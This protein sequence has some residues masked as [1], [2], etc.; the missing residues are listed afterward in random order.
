MA[1]NTILDEVKKHSAWNIFMGLLMAALGILLMA[2]PFATGA[3]TTV[4]IGWTLVLA[5]AADDLFFRIAGPVAAWPTGMALCLASEAEAHAALIDERNLQM[6]L[7]ALF[8]YAAGLRLSAL[9]APTSQN[10]PAIL[11]LGG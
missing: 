4:F 6:A 8:A 2:Y 9:L 1:T 11:R 3:I 5:G 7:T 10:E